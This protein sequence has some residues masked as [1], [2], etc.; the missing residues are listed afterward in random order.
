MTLWVCKGGKRG[1]RESRFQENNLV[2]IGFNLLDDLSD[3]HSKEQLKTLY[4]KAWPDASEGRKSN[5]VGQLYAFLKKVKIGDLVVVP[6]KTNGTIWIGKIKSEYKFRED[7][8]SDMKHTRDVIWLRKNVPRSNFDKAVLYTFGSAMTFSK[9]ER[10]QAEEKVL[11]LIKEKQRPGQIKEKKRSKALEEGPLDLE[12]LATNQLRDYI[13]QKFK[14]HELA[15]LIA[16]ILEAQGFKTAV[17]S[18]GPD[19][20]VDITASSGSLGLLEPRICVQVKS[21]ESPIDVRVY[22]ELRDKTNKM[23][24]TH[25]LLVS[26]GGFKNSINQEAKD[27]VF[28]IQ[29]WGSSEVIE[30]LL[31]NYPKLRPEIKSIIP[32]KQI[33]ILTAL[34]EEE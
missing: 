9:A 3:V 32:L 2:A 14:G 30:E 13:S 24:A 34:E 5:H 7:L 28:F 15:W 27:D 10:H 21:Q 22:R 8:G 6:M 23:G 17:S 16:G 26:W 12:E 31:R 11:A 20:G 4:E 19:G 1:E 18:P 29:L 25:G 33:W